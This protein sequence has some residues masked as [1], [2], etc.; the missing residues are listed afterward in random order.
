MN[1]NNSI[2]FMHKLIQE[3]Y[4]VCRS[5]LKKH[6]WSVEDALLS[7]EGLRK[8]ARI[9]R[10]TIDTFPK[11]IRPNI[12]NIRRLAVYLEILNSREVHDRSES[13][14]KE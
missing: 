1:R 14:V 5:Q 11:R 13:E 12:F 10:K 6:S 4:S 3:P 8:L 7:D 9:S 2:E